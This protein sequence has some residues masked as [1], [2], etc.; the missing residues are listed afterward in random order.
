ME[1]RPIPELSDHHVTFTLKCPRFFVLSQCPCVYNIEGDCER[2]KSRKTFETVTFS[3]DTKIR[4]NVP[5][6][7]YRELS[8]KSFEKKR[9]FLQQNVNE[10]NMKYEFDYSL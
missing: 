2:T 6:W 8:G 3:T 1:F 9:M 4:S 5:V 7:F 10:I